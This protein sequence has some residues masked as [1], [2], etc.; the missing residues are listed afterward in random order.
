MK[1]KNKISVFQAHLPFKSRIPDRSAAIPFH[2]ERRAFTILG[3]LLVVFAVLYS[4]FV[5]LSVSHVVVR[6]EVMLENEQLASEVAHLEERYLAQSVNITEN[7]ALAHGFTR[8]RK[9]TFVERGTL[10]LTNAQ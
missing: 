8:S 9:Q 6:E 4:Y 3:A 2:I 1:R 5:M 10:T 7:T